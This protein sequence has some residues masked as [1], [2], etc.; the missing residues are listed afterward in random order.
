MAIEP[1]S[2]AIDVRSPVSAA[3]HML[4]QHANLQA[5]WLSYGV[6]G[7]AEIVTYSLD[8]DIATLTMDDGKAN[9]MAPAMSA[10]LNIGLDRAASEAAAVVI[11]GREGIFCGGFDLKIIRG[12]DDAL[13]AQMREAGMALLKRLYLSPQPI[14]FAVTGHAVAMG[15]LLILA[16]DVRVGIAGDFRI[17]LNETSIGLSLPVTGLEIARDRLAPAVFQRATIN[18]ELFSPENAMPAGY[19]DQVVASADFD[20]AVTEA[21]KSLAALDATAFAETKRR[22][23]RSTLDRIGALEG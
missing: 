15:A 4:R 3:L 12:S 8:G 13:K 17:G 1:A 14:I 7:L 6:P 9:A 19:L 21:S 10:A 20:T 11:R 2:I 5:S 22:V 23:R 16:G 18:A